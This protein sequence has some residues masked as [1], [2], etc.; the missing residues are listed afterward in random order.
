MAP[1]ATASLGR[2]PSQLVGG[3]EAGLLALIVLLFL[4]GAYVNPTFFGSTEAFPFG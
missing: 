1:T 2:A 4:G 3:W